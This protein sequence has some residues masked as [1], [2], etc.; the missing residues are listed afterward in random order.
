MATA[1]P[2]CDDMHAHRER[3]KD[4]KSCEICTTS[5]PKVCTEFRDDLKYGKS[6]SLCHPPLGSAVG[7]TSHAFHWLVCSSKPFVKPKPAVRP[8]ERRMSEP[9]FAKF[10]ATV[11]ELPKDSPI[12]KED[13]SP[14]PA[15]PRLSS[16]PGAGPVFHPEKRVLDQLP[17]DPR[18]RDMLGY[19][20]FRTLTSVPPGGVARQGRQDALPDRDVIKYRDPTTLKTESLKPDS[21]YLFVV[22]TKDI[23][24]MRLFQVGTVKKTGRKFE[25]DV[26]IYFEQFL[27]V[28]HTS[29]LTEDEKE[30]DETWWKNGFKECGSKGTDKECLVFTQ[31]R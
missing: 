10:K 17:D 2:S 1:Q 31:L 27:N 20:S 22:L 8:K 23:Y 24:E 30:S 5:G 4:D 16:E 12:L 29:L 13:S 6:G 15:L 21:F 9:E 18:E 25:P 19:E 7:E 3:Y 14:L 28:G 11:R 26:W